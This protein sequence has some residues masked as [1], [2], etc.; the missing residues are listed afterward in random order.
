MKDVYASK[1]DL[2]FVSGSAICSIDVWNLSTLLSACL[3]TN[4]AQ[5][6][7]SITCVLALNSYER[8]QIG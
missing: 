2:S 8:E 4:Q 6:I 5:H 1:Q 7:K 3:C